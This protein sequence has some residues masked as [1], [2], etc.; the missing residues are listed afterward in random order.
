MEYVRIECP[1]D[2]PPCH[3]A[4]LTALTATL[5][6]DLA[7][8]SATVDGFT[9]CRDL[10]PGA[11]T[12]LD[13]LEQVAAE[14]HKRNTAASRWYRWA[15]RKGP[16][17]MAVELDLRTAD[18]SIATAFGPYSIHAELRDRDGHVKVVLHDSGLSVSISTT[19]AD[20]EAGISRILDDASVI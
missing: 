15:R 2:D 5:I 7:L 16:T 3:L 10:P 1:G 6:D 8:L 14:K 13:R 12:A 11:V 17:N 9:D 18:R 20:G 4:G 19:D